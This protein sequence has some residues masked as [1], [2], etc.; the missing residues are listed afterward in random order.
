[1][2][3][4]HGPRGG[5]AQG[6]LRAERPPPP[7]RRLELPLRPLHHDGSLD[8]LHGMHG[9]PHLTA[10]DLFGPA[11]RGERRDR[12]DGL[13]ARL[14]LEDRLEVPLEPG[15]LGGKLARGRGA[16][17]GYPLRRLVTEMA[18]EE[19]EQVPGLPSG[20]RLRRGCQRFIGGLDPARF[21]ILERAGQVVIYP[22]AGRQVVH[23]AFHHRFLDPGAGAQ[24]DA[25]E[26]PPYGMHGQV[27][28]ARPHRAV[29]HRNRE[30]DA[31]RIARAGRR[32]Q[33]QR[34]ARRPRAN[35]L[36][37]L[38]EEGAAKHR[39]LGIRVALQR[40]DRERQAQGFAVPE[41]RAF[42]LGQA[43]LRMIRAECGLLHTSEPAVALEQRP[44]AR[45]G[46]RIVVADRLR[47]RQSR[48]APRLG[49]RL[50]APGHSASASMS[51]RNRGRR[52]TCATSAIA[53]PE[54]LRPLSLTSSPYLGW[55]PAGWC[56][57]TPPMRSIDLSAS[58]T[59]VTWTPSRWRLASQPA[60][61]TR[62]LVP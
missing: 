55:L 31:P 11:P 40:V 29:P 20:N 48:L 13:R 57:V 50:G 43:Q 18:Q 45:V 47:R 4:R 58:S 32:D 14:L 52:S 22:R 46:K 2:R 49:L 12:A 34:Q 37:Q 54:L 36:E 42:G 62:W 19:P 35:G 51:A 8:E 9:R 39:D 26:Q 16:S 30:L 41:K 7:P 10:P 28:L 23:V 61:R 17:R 3:T 60:A 44:D 56:V 53:R 27:L 25:R 1:M 33:T 6:S 59:S 5:T 38:G 15:E 24:H 21:E